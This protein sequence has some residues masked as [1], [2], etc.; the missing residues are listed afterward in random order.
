VAGDCPNPL[1]PDLWRALERL[2]SQRRY[3]EHEFLF[4]DG[5]PCAGIYLVE[6]GEIRLLLPMRAKQYKEFETASAGAV[7]G[8]SEAMSGSP[9][10]MLAEAVGTVEVA[11]IERMALLKFLSKHCEVCMQVV[12]LLSEDLHGLYHR[13]RASPSSEGK[14]RNLN[15]QSHKGTQRM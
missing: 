3:G 4:K 15:L 9:H 10:K 12:A 11:Y 14:P 13:F 5:D 1:F 8:L 7:L 6:K 2:R